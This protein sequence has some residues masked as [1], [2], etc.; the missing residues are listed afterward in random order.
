MGAMAL[1]V[2]YTDF[3]LLAAPLKR[4]LAKHLKFGVGKRYQFE[5]QRVHSHP[6]IS[7]NADIMTHYSAIQR[8][9]QIFVT[10]VGS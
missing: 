10:L 3:P 5:Q 9:Y 8:K 7:V 1:Y 6:R 2:D 4:N